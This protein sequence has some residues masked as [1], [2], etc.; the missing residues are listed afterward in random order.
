M[1]PESGIVDDEDK[2]RMRLHRLCEVEMR[3]LVGRAMC[4]SLVVKRPPELGKMRGK[5]RERGGEERRV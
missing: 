3:G 1:L 2:E 5:E 4:R